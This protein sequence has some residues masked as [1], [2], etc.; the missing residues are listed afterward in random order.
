MSSGPTR[1]LLLAAALTLAAPASVQA[2]QGTP[3]LPP[4]TASV[5]ERLVQRLD[6][7]LPVVHAARVERDRARA[8]R[9]SVA[10]RARSALVERLDTVRVGPLTVLVRREHAQ[11]ASEIMASVW[12]DFAAL[13]GDAAPLAGTLFFFDRTGRPRPTVL[14]AEVDEIVAPAWVPRH[15]VEA[16][17]ATVLGTALARRLGAPVRSWSGGWSVNPPARPEG[18]YRELA[19]RG[20]AL[21]RACLAGSWSHCWTA[22]GLGDEPPSPAAWYTPEEQVGL[23]LALHAEW[24][25]SRFWYRPAED[26]GLGS[27]CAA[28]A[29]SGGTEACFAFVERYRAHVPPPLGPAA[30][31]ALLWVA[32]EMGGAG[33]FQDLADP[34]HASAEAAL[35]AAS[36]ASAEAL[37]T[38]WLQRVAAH[39]P[40]VYGDLGATG[41]IAGVWVLVFSLLALRSSRWRFA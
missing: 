20:N 4:P 22:L 5:E 34:A 37:A 32:L 25:R 15:R 1:R 9:D 17:A 39:R 35:L 11:E 2:R 8:A 26:G 41:G 6:S 28:E 30:R 38:A 24:S 14:P 16:N 27:R 21:N 23:A 40:A 31:Q 10:Q 3:A 13:V 36:G 19:G 18:I 7:L 12:R 33:A 29:P